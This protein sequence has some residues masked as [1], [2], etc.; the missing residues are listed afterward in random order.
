MA[1]AWQVPAITP[2]A[3]LINCIEVEVAGGLVGLWETPCD[4]HGKGF[5]KVRFCH[6]HAE[7]G[8]LRRHISRF[9]AKLEQVHQRT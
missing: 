9:N 7:S 2:V 3:P 4:E 6:A 1:L 5:A 8:G